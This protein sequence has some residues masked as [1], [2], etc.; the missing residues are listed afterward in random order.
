M[1]HA[2]YEKPEEK[3]DEA[4]APLLVWVDPHSQ[5]AVRT[6][7]WGDTLMTWI[8]DLHYSLLLGHTGMIV[9]G[10]IGIGLL[11]SLTVGVYLWWPRTGKFRAALRFKRGAGATRFNFDLHKLTGIYG[12]VLL[13]TIAVSG[14][15]MAFAEYVTPAINAMTTLTAPP[16]NLTSKWTASASPIGLDKA[17]IIAQGL[18]P[19]A[20][21]R[22]VQTPDGKMG[23]YRVDLRQ[24]GDPNRQYP[25]THVWID[26]YTGQVLSARDRPDRTR[27]DALLDWL[28]PLHNGEAFGL[29]GRILMC[30][31]GLLPGILFVTGIRHWLSKR[32]AARHRKNLKHSPLGLS[33][34]PGFAVAR[35]T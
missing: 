24:T 9:M 22:S 4:F 6:A 25:V 13:T 3:A 29:V 15:Y 2:W 18:Y 16:E 8:Y 32:R 12:L 5:K 19:Q 28:F 31:T 26:R 14:A 11:V 17:M 35:T 27:G 33:R 30:I 10:F 23:V 1:L 34:K 20:Q 7:F 21:L